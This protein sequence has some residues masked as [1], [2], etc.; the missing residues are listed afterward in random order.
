MS[1]PLDSKG[2]A[3]ASDPWPDE[4][5]EPY[6]PPRKSS[7]RT[8]ILIVI[9]VAA[10]PVLGLAALFAVL[11]GTRELAH[12]AGEFPVHTVMAQADISAWVGLLDAYALDHGG[13]YPDSLE[14]AR[15]WEADG[16]EWLDRDLSLIDPW[17]NPYH[18]EPSAG[19]GESP[20]VASWGADGV[21]GGEGMDADILST[22]LLDDFD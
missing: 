8:V 6:G 4:M 20:L 15:A 22:T 3:T 19:P 13:A 5:P 18:Y 11:W 17:G 21:E 7:K 1:D 12:I 9:A 10:V 14:V 2:D 16:N